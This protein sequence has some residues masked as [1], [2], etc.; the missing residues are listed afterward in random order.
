MFIEISTR[1]N[2][3]PPGRSGNPSSVARSRSWLFYGSLT[4]VKEI[5]ADFV[6]IRIVF[7]K[8]FMILLEC[9]SN[10]MK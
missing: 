7:M 3:I 2:E 5:L 1:L 8:F 4:D 10:Q 9:H 6:E